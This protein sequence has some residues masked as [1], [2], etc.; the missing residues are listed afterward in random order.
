MSRQKTQALR[1]LS[2]RLAKPALGAVHSC[3]MSK[4]RKPWCGQGMKAAL[5]MLTGRHRQQ[6][7]VCLPVVPIGKQAQTCNVVVCHLSVGRCEYLPAHAEGAPDHRHLTANQIG[8]QRRHSIV[9]TFTPA[10]VHRHVSTLDIADLAETLAKGGDD[11]GGLPGGGAIKEA[12]DWDS[13]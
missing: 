8:S 2:R 10:I 6:Q 13:S 3:F 11:M 7:I 9:V 5:V 1:N 4:P 12:D